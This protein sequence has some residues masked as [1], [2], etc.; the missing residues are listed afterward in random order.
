MW[1]VTILIRIAGAFVGGF[2]GSLVGFGDITGFN[3]KPAAGCYRFPIAAVPACSIQEAFR[4]NEVAARIM[5]VKQ[6]ET[7]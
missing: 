6:E 3:L 2:I 4:W 1:I 5:F 7:D